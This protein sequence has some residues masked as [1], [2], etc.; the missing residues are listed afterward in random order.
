MKIGTR[1][2]EPRTSGIGGPYGGPGGLRGSG[3]GISDSDGES[4]PVMEP[5]L[6]R[7]S[8]SLG[9]EF[10]KWTAGPKGSGDEIWFSFPRAHLKQLGVRDN[11]IG[12]L[13]AERG[14]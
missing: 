1:A 14:S 6:G 7:W 5:W 12:D 11:D 9:G 2:G 13:L 10:R 8:W 4:N 3:G